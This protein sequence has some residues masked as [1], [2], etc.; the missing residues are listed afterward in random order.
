MTQDFFFREREKILHRR[1]PLK[2]FQI[3][4]HSGIHIVAESPQFW[5]AFPVPETA[6]H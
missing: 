5:T 1:K 3:L 4:F 6:A 2:T